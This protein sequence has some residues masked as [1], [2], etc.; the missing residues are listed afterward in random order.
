VS[1]EKQARLQALQRQSARLARR[2]RLLEARSNRFSWI[3]LAIFAGGLALSLLLA[4]LVR[5]WSGLGAALLTLL[6]FALV[7]HQ[8]QRIDASLARH[9]LLQRFLDEQIAR[10]HVDWEQLPPLPE[11]S[12]D[13]GHPFDSDLDISGPKSLQRLLNTAVTREGAARLRSWLLAAPPEAATLAR[14]RALIAELVP[15]TLLRNRLHIEASIASDRGQ[16][17]GLTAGQATLQSGERLLQRLK[18]QRPLPG[19]RPALAG[20]FFLN[21]LT[22]LL[23]A[24]Q[25][26][27]HWPA[28]WSGT[29]LL[30]LLFFLTRRQIVSDLFEEL[31][32]LRA[33]CLRFSA[34]FSRLERRRYPAQPHLR[35]LCAVFQE[36][37]R[38]AEA[39]RRLSWL[40]SAAGIDK[41]LLLRLLVHLFFPWDYLLALRL[42][43]WKA[44]LAGRLPGWLETWTELEA[45]CSLATFAYLN[46]DYHF[47]QIVEEAGPAEA[48]FDGEAVGHPLLPPTLK[49]VNDFTL[50]HEGEIA[51]ITGSNMAGKSTFLRT[52]GVNVCLALAG[53]P[54]NARRLRLRPVRLFACMRIIDA[55]TEGYSYFYAEVRRLRLLLDEVERADASRPVLFLIDEMFRGTNNRE[56][57]IGS[58]AYLRALTK[59]HC[60]G[61]LATHDLELTQL[62]D[63]LPGILN[64]HLREEIR[65]GKMVFDYRLRPG[66]CPTTN[67]LII[68]R[69]LGLPVP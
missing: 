35:Q 11:S 52:I 48:L 51:I 15:L 25:L 66:P 33:Y 22:W 17:S 28:W 7:V 56:R 34:A 9:R 44:R 32:E 62:A 1:P 59:K 67:A 20:A 55:L 69:L 23:L 21:G 49:V 63:E 14:R 42:N 50:H 12:P 24:A 39:L 6:I 18:D 29:A 19:L 8:H 16:S 54:V 13:D 3:R 31:L 27:L 10:I 40:L 2:A 38:P 43:I 5:W 36:D 45:L 37:L 47:P 60:A 65:D 61:L 53:A 46:P 4:I 57:R 30:A 58:T 26:L 68:M 41:N 64:Y